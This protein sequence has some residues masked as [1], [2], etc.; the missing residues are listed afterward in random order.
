MLSQFFTLAT[1][2]VA[3]R[4]LQVVAIIL[5]TRRVGVDAI[6]DFGMASVLAAYALLPVL[7]G[8][9]PMAV[10]AAAQKE[11]D[12][13]NAAGQIVGL[14]LVFAVAAA[15]GTAWLAG[16]NRGDAAAE[17]WL[18]LSVTYFSSALAPRWVFLATQ[19]PGVLALAV[20]ISQA[21]FLGGV[22]T[23][24]DPLSLSRAAW[25]QVAGEAV[26]AGILWLAAGYPR[27]RLSLS[28]SLW[29]LRESWPVTL[30]LILG[31]AMYNFDLVALGAL[32]RRAQVGSYLASYR[33]V[34]IFGPL[35]TALQ[36]ALLPRLA[37]VSAHVPEFR[38][39]VRRFAMAIGAG[40]GAAALLLFLFADPV[41]RLLYGPH[42]GESADFLRILAWVLPVQGCRAV[43]RQALYALRRQKTELRAIALGSFTNVVLDLA[44]VP[45][46]GAVGCAWST[47]AAEAVLMAG[48]WLGVSAATAEAPKD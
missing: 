28:F 2:E 22:L 48:S 43:M 8:F 16:R 34:T 46:F 27:P 6:G 29:I 14:R 44:L 31:T 37:G 10:R 18:I 42:I 38:R 47:V 30:S 40:L 15:L 45:E 12:P 26:A 3:A 24:R 33:C 17:M 7:Q 36:N 39:S 25:A 20:T 4:G 9:D 19:R 21:I 1:G 32:G 11:L 23:V 5:L 13:G 41:L 35:L